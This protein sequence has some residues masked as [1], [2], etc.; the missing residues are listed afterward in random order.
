M[1]FFS[2]FFLLARSNFDRFHG[3]NISIDGKYYNYPL[4]EQIYLFSIDYST[5]LARN[6]L[7]ESLTHPENIENKEYL[8]K[9]A[10]KLMEPTLYNLLLSNLNLNSLIP[11]AEFAH[12]LPHEYVKTFPTDYVNG[13]TT[14]FL[15]A[16]LHKTQDQ[17]KVL[18]ALRNNEHIIIRFDIQPINTEP[19]KLSGYGVR[20]TAVHE[21]TQSKDNYNE[22]EEED[23]ESD[24]EEEFQQG[25]L[26]LNDETTVYVENPIVADM[27]LEVGDVSL[28]LLQYISNH[29]SNS[30]NILEILRDITS[31]WPLYAHDI[32][33]TDVTEETINFYDQFKQIIKS[34]LDEFIS[35]NGRKID[36]QTSDVFTILDAIKD[37]KRFTD[38]LQTVFNLQKEE[39]EKLSHRQLETNNYYFDYRSEFID[40]LNDIEQEEQFNRLSS[41]FSSLFMESIIPLVRKNLVDIVLYVDP[42][43]LSGFRKIH[44]PLDLLNAGIPVRVGIV[45]YFNL[46][47]KLSRKVA[48]AYHHIALKSPKDAYK[49]LLRVGS[50]ASQDPRKATNMAPE[51]TEQ[52]FEKAYLQTNPKLSILDWK[53]LYRLYSPETPEY[54]RIMSVHQYYK[55]KG[56]RPETISINGQIENAQETSHIYYYYVVK[57]FNTIKRIIQNEGYEDW[58]EKSTTELLDLTEYIVDTLNLPTTN[59]DLQMSLGIYQSNIEQ[60]K[61]FIDQLQHMKWD[62]NNDKEAEN[63]YILFSDK[64]SDQQIFKQFAEKRHSFISKFAINPQSFHS[65]NIEK[66]KKPCLI[67]GGR[68][69]ENINITA[70]NLNAIEQWYIYSVRTHITPLISQN[71]MLTFYYSSIICDWYS[72]EITRDEINPKVY[73]IENAQDYLYTTQTSENQDFNICLQVLMN[74]FRPDF[75]PLTHLLN[76]LDK[77][78]TCDVELVISPSKSLKTIRTAFHTYYRASY[79]EPYVEFTNL[80]ETKEYIVQTDAPQT[81][82][83]LEKS[84]DFDV[85]KL[86][87]SKLKGYGYYNVTYK[88]ESLKITGGL[89]KSRSEPAPGVVLSLNREKETIVM[90]DNGYWQFYVDPSS[91]TLSFADNSMSQK[92]YPL[93]EVININSYGFVFTFYQIKPLPGKESTII[94]HTYNKNEKQTT[95]NVFSVITGTTDDEEN[96]LFDMIESCL[97]HTQSKVKFFFINQFTSPTLKERLYKLSNE[98]DLDIAFLDYS[99]PIWLRPQTEYENLVRLYKVLFLDVLFP[100]D[101]SRVIFI[102]PSFKVETDLMELMNMDLGEAAIGLSSFCDSNA[103]NETYNERFWTNGFWNNFL[104]GNRLPHYYSLDIFVADL[105]Q[106]REQRY[107]DI[108]RSSYQKLSTNPDSLNILDQDLINYIQILLPIHP[109]EDN[110]YWS[111]QWCTDESYKTAKLIRVDEEYHR[112]LIEKK[113]KDQNPELINEL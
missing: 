95:I 65:N 1:L 12:S 77:E 74:P 23:E 62:Y 10:E 79:D 11:K 69:F 28:K 105:N 37:E 84:S 27:K 13:K 30:R 106:L 51:F 25:D 24:D 19:V 78:K 50:F 81:W 72:Q 5:D 107:A 67:C 57:A 39:I 48:F 34:D 47:N 92:Y 40:Y 100:L 22:N 14:N 7:I 36:S 71:E 59:E 33:S 113:E 104:N 110:W 93:D 35:V 80:L 15:F 18:E 56:I 2:F 112:K 55:D 16:N 83:L 32:F 45:P 26:P 60:Q 111:E 4:L 86:K 64:A 89:L 108:I 63:Y 31:N 17:Q 49:F 43:T 53:K 102:D 85:N 91:Y 66:A 6:F 61:A 88:L 38:I 42:S 87:V 97:S 76:Y 99:M 3:I 9:N 73:G 98:K 68:I 75:Q 8:L 103:R 29:I 90:E 21:N 94:Q 70:D 46:N 58:P 44:A 54:K 20:L 101:I 82:N 96:K 41:N 109:L 52:Q